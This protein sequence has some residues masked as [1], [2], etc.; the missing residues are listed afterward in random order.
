[1]DFTPHTSENTTHMLGHLGLT[2]ISDLFA[3]LPDGVRPAAP[4]DLPAPM[5]EMEVMAHIDGLGGLNRSGLV[6]FA[7]GGIYDHY[8]PPVVRTLTMRPEFVTSYTP[9][10]SELSQGV[11]QMLFEYQ[12]MIA[13]LTGLPVSNS[14]L[15]DGP[16]SGLEAIN[17]AVAHTKRSAVWISRGVHPHTRQII[18]TFAHA[19]E[20]EIVE[21]PLVGG[22]TVWAVENA[23]E[24][25]AIV[26][27]Q[28]N[29]LGVIEDYGA[30]R[31]VATENGAL[32]VAEVDAMTL[33]I[34]RSPGDA[35]FDIAFAE[36]QPFGSPMSFGG[37]VLGVFAVSKDLMRKIPG[38]LVGR[39]IDTEGRGAYTLTFRAR[40]QDIRREKASSN[41]CTNQSLNAIA[42]AI[43]LAW[44]GPTGLAEVG[45]QSVQKAHYLARRLEQLHGVDMA[46]PDAPYAREFAILTP[47]DPHVVVERMAERGYLAGIALSDNF[48]EFGGGLLVAVTEKRSMSEL[49]GYVAALAEVL[50]DD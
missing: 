50:A 33:G 4:L 42:A 43:H 11:L 7:G 46:I 8:L 28:P 12:S 45:Y 37:P 40:E 13:S 30:A 14:S 2:E 22:R 6:T 16:S 19:R 44:L 21:H 10:Q 25:A 47:A 41:I 18:T 1:V 36:G 20:I 3:H 24:P 35:G 27:S 32:A 34:L 31:A 23:P 26:M 9:Y 49:D 5:S 38:R 39:T 17:L 48:P 15:Y 29:Y